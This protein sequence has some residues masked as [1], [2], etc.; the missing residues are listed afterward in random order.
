MATGASRLY[1]I[2]SWEGLFVAA[3]V[4]P[5]CCIGF[6][7]QPP[8]QRLNFPLSLF[9]LGAGP[10]PCVVPL[11]H[12]TF[13]FFLQHPLNGTDVFQNRGLLNTE[14]MCLENRNLIIGELM[15]S[16]QAEFVQVNWCVLGSEWWENGPDVFQKS[17]NFTVTLF[18]ARQIKGPIFIYFLV[19]APF[20]S[21][22]FPIKRLWLRS[23]CL[24]FS[25]KCWC[26]HCRFLFRQ[27]IVSVMGQESSPRH[28][29]NK[30]M[31][32]ELFQT[33]QDVS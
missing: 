1:R 3:E 17:F 12:L 33:G 30:G 10:A 15:C 26:H 28:P 14:L 6:P 4:D 8:T 2:F 24:N 20:Y 11:T 29:G 7:P 19:L 25:G 13:F 21:Q 22:Y 18:I 32:D 27:P 31:E 5:T 16:T 23:T 9:S